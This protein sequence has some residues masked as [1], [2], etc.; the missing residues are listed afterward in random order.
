MR[1]HDMRYLRSRPQ[2]GGCVQGSAFGSDH[3]LQPVHRQTFQQLI[4]CDQ[5]LLGDC[6]IASED[7]AEVVAALKEPGCYQCPGG[8]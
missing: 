6:R 3:R 1:S 8:R 2:Y 7:Q 5:L 4:D